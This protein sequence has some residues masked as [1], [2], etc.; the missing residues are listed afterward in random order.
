MT[1]PPRA[2]FPSTPTRAGRIARVAAC[3]ALALA[4]TGCGA[5][6]RAD[7]AFSVNGTGYSTDDFDAIVGELIDAGQFTAQPGSTKIKTE[8][9]RVVL[10]ELIRYESF[11]QFIEENGVTIDQADRAEVE[12]QAAADPEFAKYG[13]RLKE[14]LVNLSVAGR[15]V[16]RF[17]TP[18]ARTLERVYS[19]SPAHLGVLC[20]S[21][22][23]LKTEADARSVLDELAGGADFASVAKKRSIEPGAGASGGALRNGDEDCSAL[24]ELQQGFDRDFMAGAIDAKPG[25]PTGPVKTQFGYHVIL[26]HTFDEAGD[27]VQRVLGAS[28]GAAMLQGFMSTADITVA[29]VYGRWDPAVASIS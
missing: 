3:A 14:L 8:E 24:G 20:L 1:V 16:E 6:T 2:T 25:V 18:D 23:L 4:L 12:R 21:H 28:G 27:S 26:S 11:L 19:E 13:E 5:V 22:I 10:K 9:A 15:T 7:Q 17:S 29:S